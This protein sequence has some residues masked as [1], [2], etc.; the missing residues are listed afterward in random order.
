M[1]RIGILHYKVGDTDGVSLEIAK[2]KAA[3]E[4][5][6][7]EVFLCAGDL[8]SLEGTCIPEMFHHTPEA[9]RLY[10]NTFIALQG[11]ELAYQAELEQVAGII[12]EKLLHFVTGNQLDLLIPHNLWSV[13]MNPAAALALARVIRQRNLPVFAQHH[14]FY[15]ER[16][17]GVALTCSTAVELA[18]TVLPPR[19]PRISH[20]V[21][22]S[23]ARDG[24]HRRKGIASM[25]IPNV[26]DFAAPDWDVDA[27]NKDFR[28]EIGLGENDIYILQAT[29][30]VRRKGIELAVDFVAALNSPQRRAILEQGRLYDGRS[31]GADDRI[32]LVLAGYAQDDPGG[33]YVSALHEKIEKSGI[34]AIFIE[35]RVGGSRRMRDGQKIY[36]LWDTYVF[37]DFVTYPSL[38]E[39][40][41]NQLLEAIR[42]GLPYLIFEYPVYKIDIKG[43]GLRSVS[44][45]DEIRGTD[46]SGL[47][48]VTREQVAAAADEAVQLL[49]NKELRQE[50]VAHNFA[51]ASKHFSMAALAQLLSQVIDTL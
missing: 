25:V 3:L 32:V 33:T 7:H 2:W 44:L 50:M 16:I 19:S 13:A 38:W 24:L 4:S 6:G 28:A 35:D 11:E 45:G 22:N 15:W 34:E 12:E 23:L 41:G 31:F 46:V 8:G 20:G 48:S 17:D 29:R 18:D 40:W 9:D 1:K 39:G 14:D 27:Y 5:A 51:V 26:F 42:A 30:L 37:A 43:T 47:V 36:T 21:I 49:I 10:A